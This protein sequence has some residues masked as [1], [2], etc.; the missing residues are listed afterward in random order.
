M[1]P[2]GLPPPWDPTALLR[3]TQIPLHGGPQFD[4]RDAVG[5]SLWD[6]VY[7]VEVPSSLFL[8]LSSLMS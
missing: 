3:V 4:G 6:S 8:R 1:L 5:S 7:R 2:L